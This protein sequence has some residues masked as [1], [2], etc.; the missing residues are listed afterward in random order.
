MLGATTPTPTGASVTHPEIGYPST[1]SL[2]TRIDECSRGA[3]NSWVDAGRLTDE[4]FGDAM[5]VRRLKDE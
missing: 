5:N 3:S 1:G 4:L 2:Q